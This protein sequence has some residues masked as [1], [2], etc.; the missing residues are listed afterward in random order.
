MHR[1]VVALSGALGIS[2]I[3][4]VSV[5]IPYSAAHAGNCS[6]K[7][8]LRKYRCTVTSSSEQTRS[9]PSRSTAG[10][11]RG[12]GA[13]SKPCGAA[14]VRTQKRSGRYA[15]FV[16]PI[17]RP[18]PTAKRQR[19]STYELAL[20]AN[21]EVSVPVPVV[22]TAPPRGK[23]ELIGIPTWF[24]LD[25]AQW[26]T[27]RATASAGGASATVTASAFELLI[28]PGDGS[29]AFTCHVPWMPYKNDPGHK[30]N[31][32]HTFAHPGW[33]IARVTVDWAADWSGSDGDGG[34]LPTIG[35]TVTFPIHV[36][37]ARSELVANP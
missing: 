9:K 13:T 6:G 29:R 14:S 16:G 37:E 36:V 26:G 32:T 15:N 28:D 2:A 7:V 23:R 10:R 27:R 31:C 18:C 3:V 30:S 1:A 17:A 33:Y 11:H 24:W 22:Q 25:E 34:T 35:R 5:L 8:L 19:A 20:R 21:A 4:C 12:V